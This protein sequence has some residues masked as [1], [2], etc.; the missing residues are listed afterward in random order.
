MP[1]I[2]HT[3]Y[4]LVVWPLGNMARAPQTV[5][6]T[7]YCTRRLIPNETHL[8]HVHRVGKR[9]WSLLLSTRRR[10]TRR[11]DLTR[12]ELMG[13]GARIIRMTPETLESNLLRRNEE[14][15]RIRRAYVIQ[16][17]A[18]ANV[19]WG[20]F[21][22]DKVSRFTFDTQTTT[23]ETTILIFR[24]CHTV[25]TLLE[26]PSKTTR[27]IIVFFFFSWNGRSRAKSVFEIRENTRKIDLFFY[28]ESLSF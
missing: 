20:R 3:K 16:N 17:L 1:K 15:P 19:L 24:D 10:K 21:R 5:T 12:P 2:R 28:V 14:P 25:K 11:K 18:R 23:G 4:R 6:V 22:F 13:G 26:S 7:R 27:V 8:V 9:F